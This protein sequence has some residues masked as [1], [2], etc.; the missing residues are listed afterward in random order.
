MKHWISV[1]SNA[2]RNITR[3]VFVNWLR[4]GL[5]PNSE[6]PDCCLTPRIKVDITRECGDTDDAPHDIFH[7]P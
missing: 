7:V 2:A 6:R 5:E 1:F 4:G 3:P